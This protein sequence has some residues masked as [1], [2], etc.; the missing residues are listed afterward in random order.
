MR[1]RNG[2]LFF[3][4]K[5]L[6]PSKFAPKVRLICIRCKKGTQVS[7]RLCAECNK[8]PPNVELD[9]PGGD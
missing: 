4:Y 2:D 8:K 3:S 1:K 6:K 9:T 5:P 7:D